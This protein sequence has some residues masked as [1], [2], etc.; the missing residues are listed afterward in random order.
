MGE[1][2]SRTLYEDDFKKIEDEDQ[3]I[4]W[5]FA[6]ILLMALILAGTITMVNLFITVI[7]TSKE[8]LRRSVFE[9]NL[10]YMAQSSRMIQYTNKLISCR[11]DS[12]R[13]FNLVEKTFCVHKICG[14]K[15]KAEKVPNNIQ[16][17]ENKLKELAAAV[18]RKKSI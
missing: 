14:S 4:S 17:I 7:I 11:Q 9:E 3:K 2:N 5:T 1:F 15:C 13:N 8:K 12:K 16:A 10:F 6:M 18:R